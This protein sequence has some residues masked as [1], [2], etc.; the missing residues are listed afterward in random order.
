M[1]NKSIILIFLIVVLM[2]IIVFFNFFPFYGKN[3]FTISISSVNK[4]KSITAVNQQQISQ[5][6]VSMNSLNAQGIYYIVYLKIKNNT[7]QTYMITPS[8]VTVTDSSGNTYKPLLFNKNV[9]I[10][11]SKQAI[12]LFDQPIPFSQAHNSYLV[13]DFP[14]GISNPSLLIN[15]PFIK[16]GVLKIE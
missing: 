10:P 14:N 16:N 9:F 2:S 13:F 5:S 7:Q 8:M 15:A 1:N 6:S 4:L 11:L 3:E 12:G